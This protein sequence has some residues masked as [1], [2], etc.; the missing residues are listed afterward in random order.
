MS[1]GLGL[2]ESRGNMANSQ[3]QTN[4]AK[5]ELMSRPV[6]VFETYAVDLFTL[7]P[8]SSVQFSRHPPSTSFMPAADQGECKGLLGD[9]FQDPWCPSSPDTQILPLSSFSHSLSKYLLVPGIRQLH[10][11]YRVPC[12]WLQTF[13]GWGESDLCFG[14]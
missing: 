12:S 3:S 5:D 11:I 1:K 6:S 8:C 2:G 14:E 10:G 13:L 4:V 7:D 9:P